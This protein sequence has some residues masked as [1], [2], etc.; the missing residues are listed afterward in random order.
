MT[1]PRPGIYATLLATVGTALSVNC[2]KAD[3]IPSYLTHTPAPIG[4]VNSCGE[5]AMQSSISEVLGRAEH[6]L[7][8]E[9]VKAGLALPLN[10]E[11]R[12]GMLHALTIA[13][14]RTAAAESGEI[15]A[16]TD[17]AERL[18]S[19]QTTLAMEESYC[20]AQRAAEYE[21]THPAGVV[22]SAQVEE[23][24]EATL[25]QQTAQQEKV[26]TPNGVVVAMTGEHWGATRESRGNR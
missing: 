12:I 14:K 26:T 16:L 15:K 10:I 8:E 21:R 20:E 9:R 6:L 13:A 3:E 22:Y 24:K 25:R 18:H 4:I 17:L 5:A 2:T 19:V 7:G 23:L 1:S 11:T